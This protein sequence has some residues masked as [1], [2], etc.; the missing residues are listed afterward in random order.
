MPRF[1]RLLLN[2]VEAERAA[3][4]EGTAEK[5]VRLQQLEQEEGALSAGGCRMRS[6]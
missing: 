4:D 3:M 2:G 1:G 5:L 6:D